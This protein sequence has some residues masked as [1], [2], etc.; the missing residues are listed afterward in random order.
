MSR[1]KPKP[2]SLGLDPD[3]E[4]LA[5]LL[6][7]SGLSDAEIAKRVGAAR[8][9]AMTVSTVTNLRELAT[10]RPQNF[11]LTWVG[12]AIGYSRTWRKL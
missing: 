8:G 5:A 9:H 1:L 11:T 7:R 3:H 4:Q 10:R 12:W 2:Q 6:Q